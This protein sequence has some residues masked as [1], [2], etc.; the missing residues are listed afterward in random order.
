[1]FTSEPTGTHRH[2]RNLEFEPHG[3]GPEVASCSHADD[4]NRPYPLKN[5]LPKK[6]DD[7]EKKPNSFPMDQYARL[8]SAGLGKPKPART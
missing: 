4:S 7:S 8:P 5:V 3:L 2:I 1:M 6:R